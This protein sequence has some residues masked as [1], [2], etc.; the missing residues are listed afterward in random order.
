MLLLLLLLVFLTGREGEEVAGVP[1][2]TA[3]EDEVDCWVNE[4]K[5]NVV[6]LDQNFWIISEDFTFSYERD[7]IDNSG[8]LNCS[9]SL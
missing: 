6:I 4:F 3:V 1:S 8:Y 7:S 2:G 9:L 5:Q